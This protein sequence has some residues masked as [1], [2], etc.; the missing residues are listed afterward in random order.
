CSSHYLG[1]PQ[2]PTIPA[3]SDLYR[4]VPK[5]GGYVLDGQV[6]PFE[7]HTEIIKVREADGSLRDV[8]LQ[9]RR[10]VH[11]PIVAERNG[12]PIAMRV[13]AIDRPRLFE[14]FWKMGLAKNLAEWQDGMR[15]QQLPLFNTAY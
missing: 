6:K 7:T 1:C 8:S 11:G 15:M 4:L 2:R 13:A 10:S 12:A 14:Q 9:V 5:D 3:E